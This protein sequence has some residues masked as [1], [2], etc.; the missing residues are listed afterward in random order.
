MSEIHWI[1]MV[2]YQQQLQ[3]FSRILLSPKHD[4]LTTSECELLAWLYLHPEE[5]TPL[6]LSR[7]SGMK[8]EAVSRCLKNLYEKDCIRRKKHPLDERSYALSLTDT[9]LTELRKG[10]ENILQPFYDLWR[11][12]GPEFENLFQLV[13]K[14]VTRIPEKRKEEI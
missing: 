3:K 10:Y 12:M 5:N 4:S 13:D 14:A 8:K 11:I 7:C 2:H 1:E 9:G 6:S